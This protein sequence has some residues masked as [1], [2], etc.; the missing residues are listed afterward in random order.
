[1][2]ARTRAA[3]PKPTPT[4]GLGSAEFESARALEIA[5]A[6]AVD[7]GVR[8]AGTDGEKRAANYIRDEL[9][10]YGYQA[11]LQPFT[12]QSF[13]DVNTSVDVISPE[14]RQI[15]ASALVGSASASIEASLVAAGLGYPQ[16][17]PSGTQGSVVLVQRGEIAF[18]EKVANA[19]AAG[20]AGV[21]I[22]NNESGGF[23]GQLREPSRIP[24][25]SIS[26]EDGL[27]LIDA[28]NTGAATVR[29]A[30]EARTDT[31]ESNNVIGKPPG[32]QCR[33]VIG[34]HYDSVPAGPG[35]NDNASG[36]AVVI[37][38]ARA[39]A[40]DGAFDEACFV[41]FG[42]EARTTSRRSPQASATRSKRCSTSTCWASVTGGPSAGR[43][44]FSI[45]SGRRRT[46]CLSITR[47]KPARR[48]TRE[49]TT[50][51]SSTWTS[52]L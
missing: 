18:G 7:I 20:A 42:S 17:F 29:L 46:G 24:A 11:A 40:A 41:L 31:A 5:R 19:T 34:G 38:M 8:A 12:I 14:Q 25:A 23:N 47:S 1:V 49:A 50:L 36:T 6:L 4:P 35:A 44:Q 10:K 39:M 21:I 45:S 43:G 9:S 13:V 52:P 16:Q 22:Y 28:V 33:I 51:V 32:R 48:R 37:E 3:S 15:E 30:V 2:S 27:A 26:Q